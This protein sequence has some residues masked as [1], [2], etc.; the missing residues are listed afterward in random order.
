MAEFQGVP[1]EGI[2]FLKQLKKNNN[3]E[4]FQAN[5]DVFERSVRDPM[6]ALAGSI[7]AA[8]AKVAPDHQRDPGKAVFRIYRDTRF[9]KD[10]V[11][12]KLNV[13]AYFPHRELEKDRGAG[14]YIHV[15]PN[16]V[17]AAAGMYFAMPPDLNLVRRKIANEPE[18]FQQIAQSKGVKLLGGVTGE[19]LTRLPKGFEEHEDS[20]SSLWLKKKQFLISG[21]LDPALAQ[22]S[23]LISEAIRI[24]KAATPLVEFVNEALLLAEK[25][26]P[27]DPLRDDRLFG[28]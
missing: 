23:M 15:S 12:Y 3:R 2:A 24:F 20:T 13:G 11:P 22:T 28:F 8:L 19:E 4:W 25:N 21:Q 5:K 14:F 17:F 26:K 10:K 18:R 9:S 16:E 7:S 1:K 6:L 27:K